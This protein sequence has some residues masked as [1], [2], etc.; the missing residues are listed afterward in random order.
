M[1]QRT[2]PKVAVDPRHFRFVPFAHS[3]RFALT[4]EWILRVLARRLG[5]LA[6]ASI[7]LLL[8]SA[9]AAAASAPSV[10][11]FVIGSDTGDTRSDIAAVLPSHASVLD[12]A[13]IAGALARH[14]VTAGTVHAGPHASA[15][16][17]KVHEAASEAG[18]DAV[19]IVKPRPHKGKTGEFVVVAVAASEDGAL[20]DST[21]TIGADEDRRAAWK[22]V[23]GPMIGAV[24]SDSKSGEPAK[25]ADDE[26]ASPKETGEHEGT[27]SVAPPSPPEE[28]HEHSIADALVVGFLG[29][30][31][32]GRQFHYNDRVTQGT[33]RPYDLP[34]GALLP[35]TPGVA[36]SVE[37]YP[38]AT[39]GL[40]FLRDLG[41]SGHFGY[42]WAEASIGSI[43]SNAHWD[44]W[45]VNLRDRIPLGRSP[46]SPIVGVEAG[47]GQLAFVFGNTSA[48]S[49]D[50]LPGVNYS[51][52]RFGVDG[53]IPI[54]PAAILAG[55]AYRPILGA[56]QLGDHFPKETIGGMDGA[57][58]AALR[59]TS[60]L[61]ARLVVT[62]TRVWATFNPTPGAAYVAGGGL[63]QYIDADIGVA[64]HF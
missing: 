16:I 13:S 27:A 32:G 58:G 4:L 26:S 41:L 5:S 21:V 31:L 19:I 36:A 18:A 39:S 17:A 52:L 37:L 46:S 49:T 40:P 3:A 30:D 38:L 33:L 43:V 57:V 63:D 28:A 15:F 64:A 60:A 47:Y 24:S 6:S 61:E 50:A 45:G 23:L 53:R 51:Y 62:Y 54:G 35:E 14:G 20:V 2:T 11:L 1:T 22:K 34:S 10:G 29:L 42:S 8:H 7:L 12:D 44:T 25:A 56:G 48:I 59:L 55:V 9:T